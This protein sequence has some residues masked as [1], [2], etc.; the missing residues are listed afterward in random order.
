MPARVGSGRRLEL[1]AEPRR[2]DFVRLEQ[3]LPLATALGILAGVFGLRNRSARRGR[4]AAGP[5][6]GN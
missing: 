3:R 6:P 4:R 1:L 5:L 2:R